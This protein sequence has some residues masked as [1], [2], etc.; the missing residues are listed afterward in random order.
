MTFVIAVVLQK[1]YKQCSPFHYLALVYITVVVTG[2]LIARMVFPLLITLA[3]IVSFRLDLIINE[4]NCDED[5]AKATIE[6]DVG[7]PHSPDGGLM[8]VSRAEKAEIGICFSQLREKN[9]KQ[10]A[11]TFYVKCPKNDTETLKL[12]HSCTA[13]R[14]VCE[15]RR[16][17]NVEKMFEK[18]IIRDRDQLLMGNEQSI[19]SSTNRDVDILYCAMRVGA[20]DQEKLVSS[21]NG[22]AIAIQASGTFGDPN[23]TDEGRSAMPRLKENVPVRLSRAAYRLNFMKSCNKGVEKGSTVKPQHTEYNAVDEEVTNCCIREP[24]AMIQEKCNSS[25]H[26]GDGCTKETIIL[27]QIFSIDIL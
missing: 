24:S 5:Q 25:K 9:L 14:N 7:E 18:P 2:T 11:K 10:L 3:A 6:E 23:A 22:A 21:Q 17:Q 26:L 8:S 20:N 12:F 4:F 15:G 19:I 16:E 13:A 1:M 27:R